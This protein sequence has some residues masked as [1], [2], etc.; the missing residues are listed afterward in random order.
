MQSNGN[1]RE[2]YERYTHG[3][4]DLRKLAKE[5]GVSAE[6]IRK[7]VLE[8][9]RKE[10]PLRESIAQISEFRNKLEEAAQG[11]IG[12]VDNDTLIQYNSLVNDFD[13][14]LNRLRSIDSGTP[15][16]KIDNPC[17]GTYKAD[18]TSL[19]ELSAQ[20]IISKRTTN[21]LLRAGINT[22]LDLT[23]ITQAQLMD[24]RN[25]GINAFNEIKIFCENNN[26]QIGS[27][28]GHV[29]LFA[30]GDKVVS[31]TGKQMFGFEENFRA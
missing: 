26:I 23:Y 19:A 31:L 4:P 21:A 12:R 8:E 17:K 20:N 5:Y 24:V 25:L 18:L 15:A 28:A 29:P 9:E 14:F 1:F 30:R 3:E 10:H 13:A 11:M 6:R 22:A 16:G 2:I 27:N 7:V